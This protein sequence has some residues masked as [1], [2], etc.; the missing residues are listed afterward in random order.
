M[1]FG[2][3]YLLTIGIVLLFLL[4]FRLLDRNSR[5]LS[6]TRKYID[7]CKDDISSFIDEKVTVIKDF[8]IQFEVER[9]SA[10]ELL[11]RI[12]NITREELAQKVQALTVID[13]RIREYDTNLEELLQMT[14]RVQENLNRLRE[15]SAFVE[16][17]DKKVRDFREKIESAEDEIGSISEKLASIEADFEQENTAALEKAIEA[18]FSAARSTIL[19]MEAEAQTIGRKV[20]EHREAV[21]KLERG[22]VEK[23]ARDEERIEKLLSE[24]IDRAG[25]RA[26]KVEDAALSKLREQ[27]QERVNHIK[28]HFEEKIKNVQETVKTKTS[29]INEA[30]KTKTSEISEALKTKTGE[31]NETFKTKTGEINEALKTKT[32][33][34]NEELKKSREEWKTETASIEARQKEYIANWKKEIQELDAFAKQVKDEWAAI[35]HKTGQEIITAAERRLEEYRQVQEEQYKQLA[36]IANDTTLL[37]EELRRSMQETTN[38]VNGDFARFGNEMRVS[39]EGA[40]GEYTA[41]LQAL[42]QELAGVDGALRQDMAGIDGALRQDMTGIDGALRQDMAGIDGA[43]RQDMAGI[44]DALR[45]SMQETVSRVNN[46]FTKFGNEMR[47]SWEGVSGEYTDRL[48]AVRRELAGVDQELQGIKEKSFEN[49]SKKLKGFEDDFLAG[50]RKRSGEIDRQLGVWQNELDKR[51]GEEME[52]AIKSQGEKITADLKRFKG[53]ASAFE[54]EI[55]EGMRAAEEA[56]K[57]FGEQFARDLEDAKKSMDIIRL[58]IASQSNQAGKTDALKTELDQY[59]NNMSGTIERISKIESEISRYDSQLTQIKRLEDDVNAKMTRFLSEKH[60]IEVMENDFTRLLQTSQSVEQ[61]LAQVS[62]SDD[63]LQTMQVQLRRLEDAIKETEEKYQR[64]ER[65]GKTLQETNDGIDRNF[66]ALQENEQTVK[67]LDD[68]LSL[69]KTDMNSIRDS[70]EALSAE[71]EKARDTAEKL[72][73]LDENIQW[74][75]KRIAEMNTARESLARLATELQNLEKKAKDQVK[76]VQSVITQGEGQAGGRKKNKTDDGAPTQSV[77]ENIKKLKGQGW[78]IEEIASAYKMSK[79][80]VELTLELPS[81]DA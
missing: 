75:E 63:L 16:N 62:N 34:I 50:L 22:R 78:T 71:N 36:G 51:L 13:D 66:K 72:S 18:S 46:D 19:D 47:D 26:D 81:K 57:S 40:S 9:K 14:G 28:T 70:I 37:E 11:R 65:K 77:R 35:S 6:N 17:V 49:V 5:S 80:A 27:A 12:Q 4:I 48:Q 32:G 53:E 64:V 38:R 2:I 24:A 79:G 58:E 59:I 10:A 20:E 54:K 31:I 61:K 44:D 21:D 74:L 1:R 39:W 33:E 45:R 42:R 69:F 15:E 23:L 41:N 43:L 68:A 3:E 60:R 7:R 25:S 8:S 52:K 76:L 55:R 29:E 67:R 30:L 73:S 56:R